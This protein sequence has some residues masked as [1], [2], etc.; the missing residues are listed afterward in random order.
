MT[1]RD[2]GTVKWFN[3]TKGYGFIEV[4]GARDVFVHY[5][6][7]TGDGYRSLEEGA[8]VEFEV[9]QDAL[10]QRGKAVLLV[11]EEVG[12]VLHALRQAGRLSQEAQ[13]R[14]LYLPM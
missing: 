14:A 1:N 6:G 11:V 12:K 5:S 2:T 4:E 7:I 10:F 9:V 13:A 8:L 3:A